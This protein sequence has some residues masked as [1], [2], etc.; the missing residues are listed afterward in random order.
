MLTKQF[1]KCSWDGTHD[2]NAGVAW[3]SW[4][5][6]KLKKWERPEGVQSPSSK[7]PAPTLP[8][9]GSCSSL[10]LLLFLWLQ[11]QARCRRMQAGAGAG[12]GAGARGVR[13]KRKELLGWGVRARTAEWP[14]WLVKSKSAHVADSQLLL[15]AAD[16]HDSRLLSVLLGA[17]IE[18]VASVCPSQDRHEPRLLERQNAFDAQRPTASWCWRPHDEARPRP[19]PQPRTNPDS[20]SHHNMTAHAP[21]TSGEALP[22]PRAARQDA[23][24]CKSRK[25]YLCSTPA[26]EGSWHLTP[27]SPP[28]DVTVSRDGSR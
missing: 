22:S 20:P 25:P 14:P 7:L 17:S 12:A 28:M 5:G 10:L 8:V 3:S 1:V 18:P 2:R 24:Q 19:R 23:K 15:L 26:R 27:V 9:A 11:L 16:H 21:A 4:P 13:V 6:R